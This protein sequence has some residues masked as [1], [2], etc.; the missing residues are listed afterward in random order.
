[1]ASVIMFDIA[2]TARPWLAE[3]NSYGPS[4]RSADCY[5]LCVHTNVDRSTCQVID[6]GRWDFYV[7]PSDVIARTFVSQKSVRLSRIQRLCS[8]VKHSGLKHAI[9][10]ILEGFGGPGEIR[11]LDLFHAMEARSQ[12]RHRPTWSRQ[13]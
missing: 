11:T 6:T 12:L 9:D 1:M 13:R 10:V 8:A 5:I 3:T 7:L 4:G 2:A